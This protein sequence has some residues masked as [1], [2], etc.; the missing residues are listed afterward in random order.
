MATAN[1]CSTSCDSKAHKIIRKHRS[2]V[3]PSVASTNVSKNKCKEL[4]PVLPACDMIDFSE[5]FV[6]RLSFPETLLDVP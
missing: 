6:S 1:S 4:K 5:V 2:S 3:T